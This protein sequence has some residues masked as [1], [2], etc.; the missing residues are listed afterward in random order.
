VPTLDMYEA[1]DMRFA[2][3]YYHWFFLIQPAPL[4][5]RMIGGD[6]LFYLR[7]TLGGW[8]ALASRRSSPRRSPSTS[9]ASTA[10]TRSTRRART[11]APRRRSTSSTTAPRAP[12]ARR[13]PADARAVGNARRRRPPL[14]PARALARAMRR[15]VD[16]AAIDCGHFIPRSGP[17]TSPPASAPSSRRRA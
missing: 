7:W 8:A 10:P 1:T 16:G 2:S 3:W 14:R 11:T 12:P 5:E 15:R 4:P 6:P 9:A 13:S 17:T